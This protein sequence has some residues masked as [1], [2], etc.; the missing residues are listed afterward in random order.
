MTDARRAMGAAGEQA[1]LIYLR[2]KGF[3]L[4]DRNLRLGRTGELDL[5]MKDGGTLVFVEVK[6]MLA[7]ESIRGFDKIHDIKQRK[8]IELATIYLQRGAMQQ[9]PLAFTAVRFDAVEVAFPNHSLRRPALIH[10]PDAF[11]A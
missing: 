10:L 11:R 2:R 6:A 9:P 7:G 5:V 1:A 4:L 8:L 3:R